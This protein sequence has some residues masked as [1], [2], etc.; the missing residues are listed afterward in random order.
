M[1]LTDINETIASLATPGGITIISRGA[2]ELIRGRRSAPAMTVSV[3]T[4][5]VVA[6]DAGGKTAL[7]SAGV[8]APTERIQVFTREEVVPAR[9]EA[10][11]PWWIIYDG[12][13]F[14]VDS[15]EPWKAGGFW[16]TRARLVDDSVRVG[17]VG[18]GILTAIEA[19]EDADTMATILMASLSAY[20]PQ[21]QTR[22]VTSA[23]GE[24]EDDV[25]AFCW[26]TDAV[27][28]LTDTVS[29][30]AVNSVGVVVDL[31]PLSVVIGTTHTVALFTRVVAADDRLRYEAI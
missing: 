11:Q 2:A 16:M 15:V 10:G 1:A 18:F 9:R 31:E 20:T 3:I 28:A 12:R 14:E 8:V 5:V 27:V 7:V 24:N 23:I 17:V 26:P 30:K 22:F 21:R 25:V 29:A 6:P 19:L 13:F 4:D